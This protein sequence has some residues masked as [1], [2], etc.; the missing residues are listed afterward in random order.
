MMYP[1]QQP[2]TL[3]ETVRMMIKLIVFVYLAISA[4]IALLF[5][6]ILVGI[7]TS[8]MLLRYMIRLVNAELEKHSGW[9][10]GRSGFKYSGYGFTTL[11][12]AL[13]H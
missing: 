1:Q 9:R 6:I 8:Y 7:V 13:L 5:S 10:R 4:V 11:R 3:D 2:S 12:G